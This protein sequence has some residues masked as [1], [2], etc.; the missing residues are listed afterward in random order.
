MGYLSDL[1][2][3]TCLNK[4]ELD[5]N[6]LTETFSF[7]SAVYSNY[8]KVNIASVFQYQSRIASRTIIYINYHAQKVFVAFILFSFH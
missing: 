7:Q 2:E 8:V 1:G 6:S 5:W 4:P 3:S